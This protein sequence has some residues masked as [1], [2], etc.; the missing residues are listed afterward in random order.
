[1]PTKDQF[2]SLVSRSQ[3]VQKYYQSIWI[4]IPLDDSLLG[5]KAFCDKL[6]LWIRIPCHVVN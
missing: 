3:Q 4:L 6:S 2:V 1:L 5:T